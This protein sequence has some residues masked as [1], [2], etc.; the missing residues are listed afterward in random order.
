MKVLYILFFITIFFSQPSFSDDLNSK[1]KADAII[2][3]EINLTAHGSGKIEIPTENDLW[4]GFNFEF[5]KDMVA[6]YKGK[7]I[8]EIKDNNGYAGVSTGPS[9]N[10]AS[11]VFKE[12][13]G[14]LIISYKNNT[15]LEY[16]VVLWVRSI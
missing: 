15:N 14:Q 5:P 8:F 13:N 10:S 16:K 12:K 4:V 3:K 6:S 9:D 7:Y 11:T 1:V 2:V